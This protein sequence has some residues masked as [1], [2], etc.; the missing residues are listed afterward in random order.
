MKKVGQIMPGK[1]GP[2]LNNVRDVSVFLAKLIR[3]AYRGDLEERKAGKLAYMCN[4]L[5]G[6]LE[7][8]EIEKRLEVLETQIRQGY[9]KG[10]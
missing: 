6:C 2:R 4:V 8:S 7:V 5:K 3:E 10:I 1:K 9:E